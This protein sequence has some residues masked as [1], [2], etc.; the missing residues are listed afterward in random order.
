MAFQ[1]PE[2]VSMNEYASEVKVRAVVR[3][4]APNKA[5]ASKVIESVLGAPGAEEIG[6]ANQNNACVGRT[7]T[8]LGVEFTETNTPKLVAETE[9]AYAAA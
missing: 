6:L 5:D 8:V 4:R 2:M 7:A 9:P 3:V 1:F